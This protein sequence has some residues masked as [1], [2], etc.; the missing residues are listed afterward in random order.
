[1]GA[2]QAKPTPSPPNSAQFGTQPFPGMNSR[3]P[4]EL[5]QPDNVPKAMT[6]KTIHVTRRIRLR[7]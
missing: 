3:L 1:M 2:D 7:L 4:E 5:L 6:T